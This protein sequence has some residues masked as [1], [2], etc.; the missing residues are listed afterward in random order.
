MISLHDISMFYI[1]YPR[2]TRLKSFYC[3]VLLLHISSIILCGTR[4]TTQSFLPWKG[5]KE[6]NEKE[7]SLLNRE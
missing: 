6:R 3:S 5:E 2:K 7:S 1:L 4:E